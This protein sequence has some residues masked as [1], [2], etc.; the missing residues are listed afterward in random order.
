[1]RPGL[2]LILSG[3][4]G[5]VCGLVPL[6][7]VI[8]PICLSLGLLSAFTL[9]R[10]PGSARLAWGIGLCGVASLAATAVSRSFFLLFAFWFLWF[11]LFVLPLVGIRW[12]RLSLIRRLGISLVLP[13]LLYLG[14]AFTLFHFWGGQPAPDTE[15]RDSQQ[16]E[17]A[18]GPAVSFLTYAISPPQGPCCVLSCDYNGSEWVWKV[19]RPLIDYWFAAPGCHYY[20]P[21]KPTAKP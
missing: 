1:M 3:L 14:T 8:F 11:M 21:N 16:R 20:D 18:V 5:T 2:S 6:P 7:Q 17:P 13:P 12:Q 19:Y 9:R 4:A 15:T 10:L